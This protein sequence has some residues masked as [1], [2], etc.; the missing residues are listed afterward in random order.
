MRKAVLLYNPLAGRRCERRA[1]DV[2]ASMRVLQ[3]AGVEANAEATAAAGQAT[4]QVRE[5]IAE[6]CDTVFACGGDGTIHDVLQGLVGT[7]AALGIIP[8]GTANV[9]AHDLG[10][11]LQPEAAAEAALGARSRRIAVGKIEYHG[12][13]GK[14]ASRYFT[15]TAGVGADARLFYKLGA[16]SKKALGMA[17]Y[18]L[19]ACE[20]WL[21]HPMELFPV[22]FVEGGQARAAEVSQLL[23]VRIANFGGVLRKL[24]PEASLL[25]DDLRLV[26][27]RT[28]SRWAYLRWVVR[29][30]CGAEWQVNGI[31]LAFSSEVTAAAF[32]DQRVFVE[33]D[34]ELLGTLPAKITIVRDALTVLMP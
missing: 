8:L 28:Q 13:E 16:E 21:T 4:A 22:S 31:E 17:S 32:F 14:A 5:A 30:L 33:A 27:F 26:L 11:P 25:R 20:L 6:G 10:L 12:F 2:H 24:A 3:N 19:K 15:V 7:K 29:G 1:A 9:L 23:A 34:G 18:Y